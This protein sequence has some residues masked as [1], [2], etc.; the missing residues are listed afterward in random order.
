MDWKTIIT[1]GLVAVIAAT[2]A[3]FATKKDVQ[4]PNIGAASPEFITN[5]ISVGGMRQWSYKAA[6]ASASTTCSFLSPA[7]TSTLLYAGA[8]FT[9]T[10][11]GSFDVAWGKAADPFATTTSL[12]YKPAAITSGDQGTFVATSSGATIEEPT[13]VIAPSTYVNFKIGSSSP[14]LAG[15]CVATFIEQQ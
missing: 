13:S 11:G 12:G 9:N 10:Y 6:M 8:T 2:G 1:A 14:T 7:A 5:Y 3:V 4:V 15:T